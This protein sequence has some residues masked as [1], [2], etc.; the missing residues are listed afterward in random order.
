[1]QGWSGVNVSVATFIASSLT[2]IASAY[3]LSCN[4]LVALSFNSF[5]KS[6]WANA[7][8][9]T[10]AARTTNKKTLVA[11]EAR[12][13]VIFTDIF[14]ILPFLYMN[15]WSNWFNCYTNVNVLFLISFHILHCILDEK[16]L[17][18][19]LSNIIIDFFY[20]NYTFHKFQLYRILRQ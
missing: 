16:R 11:Q 12:C 14:T 10:N 6:S 15:G 1:M 2:F 4:S 20:D 18:S 8:K 7:G 13:L 9:Q 19:I 3:L 5:H 17:Y